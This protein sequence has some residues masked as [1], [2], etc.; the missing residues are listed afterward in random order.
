MPKK[1]KKLRY[2]KYSLKGDCSGGSEGM[3]ADKVVN[4]KT[5][6]DLVFDGK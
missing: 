3:N 2:C 4:I 1:K 6:T 5:D